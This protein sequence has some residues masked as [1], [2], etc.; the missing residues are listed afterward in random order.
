M[1]WKRLDPLAN[2]GPYQR[3]AKMPV[4]SFSMT[5]RQFERVQERRPELIVFEGDATVIGFPNR[6]RL[7]VHYGFPE[8]ILFRDHFREPF[9]QCVAASSR[10]EA[11]RGVLISFRDRPNHLRAQPVFWPL[12]LEEGREWV[13]MSWV[14]VPEQPEPEEAIEGGFTV[15]EA[16]TTDRDAIAALEAE[17]SGE[18]PLSPAGL[19]SLVEDATTVRVVADAAGK[20]VAFLALRSDPGGWGVI[21][22]IDIASDLRD[23]LREPLL[24]WAV[25]WLRNNGGRRIRRQVYLGASPELTLLRQL[26]FTP[27]ETGID[28]TRPVEDSEVKARIDERQAHGT[29][30]KFGWWR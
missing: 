9:T 29:V 18:A 27:G 19:D 17:A 20:T 5:E 15:R 6:D 16:T 30:I 23:Q 13:E 12:A 28:F 22:D 14:A 8:V 26:G 1:Q 2:A 4:K 7:E 21:Q 3:V 11:P 24:R 25:A 10:E